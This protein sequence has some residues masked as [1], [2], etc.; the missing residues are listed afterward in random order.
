MKTMYIAQLPIE[1]QKEILKK[2]NDLGLS[3]ND[4]KNAMDSRLCDLEDTIDITPYYK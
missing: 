3:K 2:L 1:I 4:I